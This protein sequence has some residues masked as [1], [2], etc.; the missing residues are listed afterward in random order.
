MDKYII[1]HIDGGAGKSVMATAVCASIKNAYP[2]H[3][4]IVVSAWPE[5]FLHNPNV[6]RVFKFGN[7]AYFY[8]DYVKDK[9]SLILRSE[10]YFSNDFIHRKKH[11]I[12]IW[13]DLFKIPCIT[14]KPELFVAQ[15]ELIHAARIINK[16]GKILTLQ[17]H[18]GGNDNEPYS[19]ARD[20]PLGFSQRLVDEFKP[21]FD[22]ILHIRKEKQLALN[23]TIQVTD[24]LRN[25][26]CFV[27]LSDK[28]ILID[29][30]IQH[31]A[32]AF[33][34]KAI[35]AWISNSPTVFGYSVHENVKPVQSPVFR[36]NID[37]YLDEH[38]WTGTRHYECPYNDVEN[39]FSIDQYK[40]Y[41]V[42]ENKLD[43]VNMPK[44]IL[45]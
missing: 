7:F 27:L 41:I 4:L 17:T 28:L 39:L 29:S 5:V 26:F 44:P 1:F 9:D 25:L 16:Q 42:G 18:G 8:E 43:F 12:E 3:K 30:M 13:C 32:A 40:D 21:N 6:Y 33:N 2:E 24:S 10:P 11:L 35:V 19:W 36:H 31:I 15:R 34:K 14:L 37:S 23:N 45:E 38:D 22:K 20:L